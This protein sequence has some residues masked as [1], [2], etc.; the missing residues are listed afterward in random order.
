MGNRSFGNY[1]RRRKI[2]LKV[3]FGGWNPGDLPGLL[4]TLAPTNLSSQSS[5]LVK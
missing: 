4:K 5:S 1:L 3:L 2:T